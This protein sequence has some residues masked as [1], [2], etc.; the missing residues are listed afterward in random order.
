MLNQFKIFIGRF[1][2]NNKINNKKVQHQFISYDNAQ[3]IGIVY[4][5][6]NLNDEQ[7]IQQFANELR[8]DGK[9]VFLLGYINQKEL[10]YKR[11][12]HISSEFYWREK[13]TFFYLP[14]P[15]KIGR[16]I[17]TKFDILLNIYHDDEVALKGISVLSKAQY[18]LG[19]QMTLA[20]Q[21]FDMTIDTGNNKDVYY[22][23][24]QM[25]YYLK[26]I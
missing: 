7:K 4:N 11:V 23:A 14:I 2:L 20:T 15:E 22:L 18:R 1:I 16:F 6:E 19:S 17:D 12:P 10:P 5:A 9:K 3:E 24:K 25:E 26:A 13:L 21:F 8:S